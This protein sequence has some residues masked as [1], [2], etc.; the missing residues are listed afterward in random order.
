M[1]AWN[2]PAKEKK[3]T[4]TFPR[5]LYSTRDITVQSAFV[6]MQFVNT[7]VLV[8]LL[9]T[10]MMIPTIFCISFFNFNSNQVESESSTDDSS[11]QQ[12]IPDSNNNSVPVIMNGTNQESKT[13][14][15]TSD[16]TTEIISIPAI[17]IVQDD[18]GMMNAEARSDSDQLDT[19]FS[20][21][22]VSKKTSVNRVEEETSDFMRGKNRRV[23][24]EDRS[25]EYRVYR[26]NLRR[27]FSN[28]IDISHI[29]KF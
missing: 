1:N 5:Y 20:W 27:S 22:V 4:K 10:F 18:S 15:S 6:K 12:T 24:S 29:L 7:K 2:P 21:L 3:W 17:V 11:K 13:R 8:L 19:S 16:N 9:G 26:D 28:G 14:T 23:V 25:E